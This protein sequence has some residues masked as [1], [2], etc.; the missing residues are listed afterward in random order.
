MSYQLP[1]LPYAYDALEPHIDTRTMEIHHQKHHGT[2]VDTVNKALE[3][4]PQFTSLSVESLLSRIKEVPEEK[5]QVV[6]NHGGGHA[7]HSLF[8][9]IMSPKGGGQPKD[10]LLKAIEKQFGSYLS[11]KE[12]FENSAKTRFGSGWAWLVVDPADGGLKVYSTANQD[13]P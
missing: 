10:D 8:W 7:N 13:S 9:E 2:Y 3:T 5:R 11:F 4:L 12:T 6:I 1:T